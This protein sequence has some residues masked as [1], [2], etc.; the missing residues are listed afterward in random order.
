MIVNTKKIGVIAAICILL[1]MGGTVLAPYLGAQQYYT[2]AGA[3]GSV[4]VTATAATCTATACIS[5]P[6]AP[7]TGAVAWQFYS[8]AGVLTVIE[9]GTVDG[10]N[11]VTLAMAPLGTVAETNVLS[12][13]ITTT[14]TGIYVSN[15]S[16]L[17]AVRIR[18]SA[19]TSGSMLV[20]GRTG[21]AP[22]SV[23]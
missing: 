9:E 23:Q 8:A 1:L 19:F 5:L 2:G 10:T 7:N 12:Y 20:T 6:V 3:T 15:V 18:C 22:M 4:T 14:G 11:W 16:G 13:A 17:S 21:A